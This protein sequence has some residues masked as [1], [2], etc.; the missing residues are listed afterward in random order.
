MT[1]W[2]LVAPLAS[3]IGVAESSS[4]EKTSSHDAGTAVAL[5]AGAEEDAG[6]GLTDAGQW[7]AG[8]SDAG[9]STP[10]AGATLVVDAGTLDAGTVA[11]AGVDAGVPQLPECQGGSIDRLASW[12]AP[13]GLLETATGV[14][15]NVL[16][17][18]NGRRV[19]RVRFLGNDWHGILVMLT[20]K[21]DAAPRAQQV[22]DAR[23]SAGFVVTYRSTADLHL[24]LRAF[25]S[26]GGPNLYA[27]TMPSTHGALATLRLPLVASAWRSLF[28]PPTFTFEQTLAQ[29]RNVTIV[30]NEPNEVQ[31]EGLRLEG[32]VPA[33]P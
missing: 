23:S 17:E 9:R 4:P 11:D 16:F 6:A 21:P 22:V 29:L 7:D 14:R 33:C 24:Q 28:Q 26:W 27:A 10:D 25:D 1:R 19:A 32:Y 15:W 13:E 5:D 31:V 30:G 12:S 18:E 3:C 20:N 2:W 8:A